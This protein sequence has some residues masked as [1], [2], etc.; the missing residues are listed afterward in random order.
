MRFEK[1]WACIKISKTRVLCLLTFLFACY[2]CLCSHTISGRN[3]FWLRIGLTP[4]AISPSFECIYYKNDMVYCALGANKVSLSVGKKGYLL[5]DVS[6]GTNLLS[7]SSLDDGLYSYNTKTQY[8]NGT[9]YMWMWPKSITWLK[10]DTC[11]IFPNH[12]CF[13]EELQKLKDL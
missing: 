13:D 8:M 3:I 6:R 7:F 9:N 11:L 12:P 10:I 5:L 2:I 4:L 1:K